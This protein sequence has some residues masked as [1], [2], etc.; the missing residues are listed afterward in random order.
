MA[1]NSGALLG[2]RI[3]LVG[4]DADA[5]GDSGAALQILG[6][7]TVSA[8]TSAREALAMIVREPPHVLVTDLVMR[9]EDGQWLLERIRALP[10]ERGGAMPVVALTAAG[11]RHDGEGALAA[12]FQAHLAGPVEPAALCATVARVLRTGP[13]ST[14]AGGYSAV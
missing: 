14:A 8:A 6:G 3:L 4:A 7:A 1:T 12:R 13:H 10:P 9:D 2:V 5:R 11:S